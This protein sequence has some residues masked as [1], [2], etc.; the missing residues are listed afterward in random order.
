[1]VLVP[2]YTILKSDNRDNK[3]LRK[4]EVLSYFSS[5]QGRFLADASAI[6]ALTK[7]Q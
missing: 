4:I 6:V 7:A 2:F 1:M 3:D 5:V